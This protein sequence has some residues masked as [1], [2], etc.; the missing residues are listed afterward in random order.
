MSPEPE[1]CDGA[2]PA[3][4]CQFTRPMSVLKARLPV[5]PTPW[6]TAVAVRHHNSAHRSSGLHTRDDDVD[7]LRFGEQFQVGAF[8]REPVRPHDVPQV[9]ATESTQLAP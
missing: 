2:I 6:G 1:G 7:Q 9:P 8:V 3:M 4:F 5:D